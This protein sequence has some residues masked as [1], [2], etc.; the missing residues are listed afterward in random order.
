M[1]T[2][3]KYVPYA[4]GAFGLGNVIASFFTQ[5]V[6]QGIAGA[7]MIIAAPNFQP[8]NIVCPSAN[9]CQNK[10]EDKSNG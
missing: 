5:N 10:E 6:W 4:I 1:K 2:I 8:D 9:C 3:A 7:W